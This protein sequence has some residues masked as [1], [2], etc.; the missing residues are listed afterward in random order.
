[1]IVTPERLFNAD[2]DHVSAPLEQRAQ[3]IPAVGEFPL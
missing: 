1:M 3:N 2:C